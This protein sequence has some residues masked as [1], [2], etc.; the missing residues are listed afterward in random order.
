MHNIAETAIVSDKVKVGKDVKIGHFSIV[1]DDV[2][3][4][5]NTE[6][7]TNVFIKSGTRI[8]KNCKIFSGAV[9]GEIPQDLKFSGEYSLLEIGDNNTIR[10]YCT[11]NRG[12]E[13]RGK[14]S[15]G[16]NCLLM[17]YVHLGHD[18]DVRDN[19]IIANSVNL[20]GHVTIEDFAG[21]GGDTSVH[22][23]CRIGQHA[24]I[25]GGFRIVRDVPPFILAAGE[26]L[27]YFGLNKVGLVRNGFSK[28][29]IDSLKKMYSY[30]IRSDLNMK[31]AFEEIEKNVQTIPE[32][33]YAM[34][35]IKD[36]QRGL[37]K[38]KS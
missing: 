12:T 20:A 34:K 29:T 26:P 38:F 32:V 16:N 17:A 7:K 15:L 1:E 18:S 9:L 5:D 25:G 27:R 6:I 3:I 19:V 24:F 11:L 30:L 14:T 31:Q 8:G 28:E 21:I 37:I 13:S 23:F 33:E 35:F 10:E 22:Q 4:G 36:T 2:E